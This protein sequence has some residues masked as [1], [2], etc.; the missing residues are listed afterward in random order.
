VCSFE[1]KGRTYMKVCGPPS[2]SPIPPLALPYRRGVDARADQA[3]KRAREVV[4]RHGGAWVGGW[5]DHVMSTPAEGRFRQ[6]TLQGRQHIEWHAR[7][8]VHRPSLPSIHLAQFGLLDGATSSGGLRLSGG[9]D[10][11]RLTAD[12][13]G[14]GCGMHVYSDV[15]VLGAWSLTTNGLRK[16]DPG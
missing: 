6:M 9:T 7:D 2:E 14:C 4:S 15:A 16:G 1:K 3:A 8:V 10:P 13:S 12:G 11:V 5:W